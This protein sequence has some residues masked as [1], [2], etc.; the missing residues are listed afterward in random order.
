MSAETTSDTRARAETVLS[1]LASKGQM[2]ATVESC[3]GGM[4]GAALTDIAGSSAVFERG[5]LTYSNEAKTEM[6]GV[7]AAMIEAHG[8]VSPEVAAA[9]AEGGLA[10]SHA[11]IVVSVTGIAGPGGSDVKPEG[12]VC[13]HVVSRTGGSEAV[14]RRFGPLGR[15]N[16]RRESVLQ[17]L[18]LVLL[19]SQRS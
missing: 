11:D 3:T 10:H 7:P 13:F 14:T 6:V 12:L 1:T 8:A 16:V 4:I 17:A 5:F 2:M 9:M 15:E 19:L 18:D